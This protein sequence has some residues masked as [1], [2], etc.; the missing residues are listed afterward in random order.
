MIRKMKL[1]RD[2]QFPKCSVE[3]DTPV[4]QG[5]CGAIQALL[6]GELSPNGG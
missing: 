6:K 1:R 2:M 5:E 3:W 4:T